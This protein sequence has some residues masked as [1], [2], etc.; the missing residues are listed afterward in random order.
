MNKIKYDLKKIFI[1]AVVISIIDF[2]FMICI[3]S[4]SIT[5]ELK[6]SLLIASVIIVCF[7][8]IFHSENTNNVNGLYFS[9]DGIIILR[10]KKKFT[11]SWN[12]IKVKRIIKFFNLFHMLSFQIDNSHRDQ[13]FMLFTASEKSFRELVTKYVPKDHQLYKLTQDY[14]TNEKI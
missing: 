6:N 2:V 4:F 10:H 5:H 1:I 8:Y 12:E 9:K 3:T 14:F 7:L 13:R 11:Q